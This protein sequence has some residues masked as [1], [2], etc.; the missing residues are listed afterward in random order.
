MKKPKKENNFVIIIE[1]KVPK[2]RR[3]EFVSFYANTKFI[4]MGFL[5]SRLLQDLDNPEIWRMI[6]IWKNRKSFLKAHSQSTAPNGLHIFHT[7][8]SE[9]TF[10]ASISAKSK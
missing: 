7:V 4:P 3:R 8:G 6:N 9:A 2:K 10:T 1:G 5:E